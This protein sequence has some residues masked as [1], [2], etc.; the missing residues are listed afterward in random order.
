M[1]ATANRLRQ[2][3]MYAVRPDLR[4]FVHMDLPHLSEMNFIT[5]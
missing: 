4:V 1:N 2:H 5:S 3:I